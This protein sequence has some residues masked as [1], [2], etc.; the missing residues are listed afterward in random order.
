MAHFLAP[1]G[2]SQLIN[3]NGVPLNGG[4]IF[5]Y[6][7]GTTTLSA[8]ATSNTGAVPQANPIILN[9]LGLPANPIWMLGGAALKFVIKDAADVT[10]ATLDNITG[11]NDTAAAI[12]DE[13]IASG[14]A[15]TYISA[16]SF[17]V[18]GDQTLIL[19]VGRRVKSTVP[20]GLIYSTITSAAHSAGVTTVVVANQTS[21]LAVGL[22]AVA[23][24]LL[25][26]TFPSLPNAAIVRTSM[27]VA[28]SNNPIFTGIVTSPK[29]QSITA[30]ISAATGVLTGIIALPN[31]AG[32]AMYLCNVNIGSAADAVNFGASAIIYTDGASA[33]I[34]NTNN[35]VAQTISLSGLIMQSTQTSGA[36]QSITGTVT[37]ISA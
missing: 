36:T 1:V 34:A 14:L 32:H 15:P 21:V 5:T 25:S 10:L 7:A 27:E 37:R 20:A 29:I 13:W 24:G 16:T 2:N 6:L 8:T 30:T 26:P 23:Y 17:S 9:S 31:I 22:S 3:A 18:L 11:I 33:R 35:A 4:K 12:I 19:Q 28:P